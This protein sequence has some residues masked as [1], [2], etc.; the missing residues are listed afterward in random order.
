MRLSPL[1]HSDMQAVI[2]SCIASCTYHDARFAATARV[3]DCP[4]ARAP[5]CAELCVAPFLA[6]LTRA[7][8]THV[9]LRMMMHSLPTFDADVRTLLDAAR[10]TGASLC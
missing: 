5:S 1:A 4:A 10:P 3:L 7:L 8:E 2:R 9:Y 6:V